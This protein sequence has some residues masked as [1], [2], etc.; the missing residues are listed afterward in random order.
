MPFLWG[1]DWETIINTIGRKYSLN[2]TTQADPTMDAYIVRD[3]DTGEA[4][5]ITRQLLYTLKGPEETAKAL[6]C[7]VQGIS[8]KAKIIKAYKYDAMNETTKNYLRY[9]STFSYS[10]PFEQQSVTVKPK[11]ISNVMPETK[12]RMITL[13][14]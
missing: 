2:L 6:E 5:R 8:E 9:A 4:A 12:K 11:R 7:I 3:I 10:V 13:E 1:K 14:E